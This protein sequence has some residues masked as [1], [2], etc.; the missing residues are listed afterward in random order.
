[1]SVDGAAPRVA[2]RVD[3][4]QAMG[5]GHLMRCLTLADALARGGARCR[6]LLGAQAAP[7]RE[8]V[9]ARGYAV[10]LLS[11]DAAIAD[12]ADAP[13]HAAWLPWGRAADAAA[14]AAALTQPV[15]WLVVDHYALDATWEA[16]LRPRARHILAIDDLA[17]RAHD[18]DLLLD[19]NLQPPGANRYA[20]LVPAGARVLLGPR[21]ALLRPAFAALRAARGP[22][23][24][25][26][27]RVV[28]F[29]GGVDAA[30][31]TLIALDA[32]DAAGFVGVATDV[33][34]GAASP[35]LGAIRARVAGRAATELHVDT[36][37]VAEL[38]AA[39][40]LALG[41]GGGAALERC[42][43]GLPTLAL[44]VAENQAAGM[45]RLAAAGAARVLP[46]GSDRVATGA[47]LAAA[48]R[49]LAGDPAAVRA[50][51][52]AAGAVTDGRGAE[53]V[54]ASLLR[55]VAPPR[56]R[57]ATRK[58]ARSLH[59]W[60]N[61]PSVRAVS[62]SGDP[63]P[64]AAHL[65]WLDRT[66]A[67]PGQMI[68]LAGWGEMDVGTVRFRVAGETATVSIALDPGL[69]GIGIGGPVL[70]GAETALAGRPVRR[71]EAHVLP[72]NLASRRLFTACGYRAVSTAPERVLYEKRL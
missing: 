5:S 42:C 4:S 48:L 9:A 72:G 31:A 3:A 69:I 52:A 56:L 54:V 55:A 29:M 67:D 28:V 44:V 12:G 26:I 39:A 21:Y 70:L 50:M 11:P 53:R 30:G 6:F 25:R 2:F 57:P 14:T 62:F 20:G 18:C 16:A 22:R 59:A 68:L 38:F 15:D 17:D 60:R 23:D 34:A 37:R 43:L 40:D 61:D 27:G 71:I 58:D 64:F 32:L 65:A 10:H 66:L 1:M 47:A 33:I 49:E 19:H 45:A 41:A 24:G 51:A 8:A 35:W 36:P 46:L 63:I 7:W 13:P